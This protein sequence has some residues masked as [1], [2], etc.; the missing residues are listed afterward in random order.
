M[1]NLK[2]LYAEKQA[3]YNVNTNKLQHID[4]PKAIKLFSLL[5]REQLIEQALTSDDHL[6]KLLDGI[7]SISDITDKQK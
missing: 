1:N 5:Y 2:R 6:I 7:K 3:G 4:S